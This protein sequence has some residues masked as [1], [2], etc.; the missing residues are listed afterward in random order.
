MG[1]IITWEEAMASTFEFC[2]GIDRLTYAS[3]PPIRADERGR[4]P[5]PVPGRWTEI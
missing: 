5:V 1:R 3:E 2:P 4:Y